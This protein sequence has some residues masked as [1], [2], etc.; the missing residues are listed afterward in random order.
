MKK[1]WIILA[2]VVSVLALGYYFAAPFLVQESDIAVLSE[3]E[4]AEQLASF[5]D[6]GSNV[7]PTFTEVLAD[8]VHVPADKSEAFTGSA[9]IDIDG[10]GVE[11]VFVGGG[12]GQQDALLK[13][14]GEGFVNL[15]INKGDDGLGFD[16]LE[17]SLG[18]LSVDSDNDGDTDLYIARPSGLYL[19]ENSGDFFR[20][21]KLNVEFEARA[22]P[23]AIASTDLNGD[24]FVDLYISTF[25]RPEYF[26]AAT[27]NDP[28]H[29]TAN[30]L[31]LNDGDGEFT[32]VTEEYGIDFEQN[33]FLSAFVDLNN[34]GLSDFVAATN[35]DRVKI[36]E[37]TGEGF[38][39]IGELGD[40]GFWMGLTVADFDNDGDSD[41]FFT[42]IGNTVPVSSARGDLR[43]DQIL[44]PEWYL[45][46]ND[47]DFN[48]VQANEEFALTGYEFA[49]G[50][51]AA[52]FN[53]DGRQDLVV[54]ENYIKWPAHKFNK[55][56]GRFLLQGNDGKFLPVGNIAGLVNEHYGMTPLVSD[57]NAD[58]YPDIVYVNYD[59]PV[60]AY[61]NDGGENHYL[62]V[63]M[64]DT[65]ASL[66]AK[67]IVWA[68]DRE[69][70]QDFVSG[71]GLISDQSSDLF[72]G[73]GAYDGVVTL[74]VIWANGEK[75]QFDD[76]EIDRV[77][78]PL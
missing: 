3:E 40:Y 49:W 20:E 51:D 18:A 37:N 29:V 58:G 7:V 5:D 45:F 75:E 46:R 77:F 22:M 16:N 8:F 56:P 62:T 17:R 73:L 70:V 35:T 60:K 28:S 67:V 39:D 76:V 34:D 6:E 42:N 10:D 27:F 50:A 52:D 13:F 55:L 63:R 78:T 74:K 66:G 31:L 24:G 25:I 72:F 23:F 41:L 57:F 1:K 32:D 19:M 9:L 4:V 47:G 33:T 14:D 30:L 36:Y 11:E 48:F 61:L 2:V 38:R 15:A 71:T 65:A 59:G 26:K 68:G 69:F 64:R 54:V 21:S 44:D 53:L 12:E 43:G